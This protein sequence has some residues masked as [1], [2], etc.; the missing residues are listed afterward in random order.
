[1]QKTSFRP[2]TVGH[3][4]IRYQATCK[5]FARVRRCGKQG[6]QGHLQISQ[7]NRPHAVNDKAVAGPAPK[8]A[9]IWAT[10]T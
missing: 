5:Q 10:E 4:G 1:M 9:E 2:V 6:P 8:R 3:F 7:R